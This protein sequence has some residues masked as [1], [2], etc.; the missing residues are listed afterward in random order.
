VTH[1]FPAKAKTLQKKNFNKFKGN[2]F[3]VID[4]KEKISQ[5]KKRNFFH[6][7]KQQQQLIF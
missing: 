3:R 4:W 6:S 1:F 7:L 5:E 2:A